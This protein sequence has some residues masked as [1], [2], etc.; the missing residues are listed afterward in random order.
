MGSYYWTWYAS[1][2]H[3]SVSNRATKYIGFSADESAS[4]YV[5]SSCN[6]A[7]RC[8]TGLTAIGYTYISTFASEPKQHVGPMADASTTEL[9]DDTAAEVSYGSPGK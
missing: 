1:R 7:S 5:D 8:R 3:D 2:I 6:P 9:G 4:Q